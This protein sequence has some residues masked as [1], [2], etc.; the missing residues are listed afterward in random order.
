MKK[1]FISI[2]FLLL[3]INGCT[4]LLIK[5]NS[6]IDKNGIKM[7]GNI[8]MRNFYTKQNISDSLKFLW[9]AGTHG[10]YA[11]TS[12][13]VNDSLVFISDLTGRVYAIGLISGKEIGQIKEKG[14]VFGSPIIYN[15]WLIYA[16]ASNDENETY[17][18]L[19]DFNDGKVFRQD[20][21]KGRV[22]T[23]IVQ[24][25]D[26]YI[27][28]TEKGTV[29][30]YNISGLPQWETKLEANVH[31]SPAFSSGL[32][33]FGDDQ[34]ELIGVNSE[35]GKVVYRK[36]IGGLFL[37]G[38][39]ISGQAAFIGNDNG[40]IYSFDFQ[41]GDIL[42]QFDSGYR[43]AMT[44]AYDDDNIYFGN[45]NGDF[46]CLNKSD[47]SLIWKYHSP[48]VFNVTPLITNNIVLAPDL[49]NS[50]KFLDK[51]TGE[52][53][54]NM[55]IDGRPKLTPVIY[56]NKLII[57]FDRGTLQAYEFIY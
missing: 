39:S 10:G 28:V 41:T 21:L 46:F 50:I 7:F 45:L 25:D 24:T 2:L 36:N 17:F 53:H 23:E 30:K 4:P 56:N 6:R 13:T 52:L 33:I 20:V 32:A 8:S 15:F 22:L 19:Y 11:N 55:E 3:I 48:G 40:K 44:P 12:V 51:N 49:K 31:S 14:T 43:I 9:E 26:G 35:D 16:L 54:M 47:G 1:I 37:S 27:M 42:W 34:G 57:G 18:Y 38:A 29:Y 5:V